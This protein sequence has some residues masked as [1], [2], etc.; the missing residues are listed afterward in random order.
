[1]N[2]PLVAEMIA[3]E[4]LCDGQL[5]YLRHSSYQAR[6]PLEL[7]IYHPPTVSNRPLVFSNPDPSVYEL[8]S[9]FNVPLYSNDYHPFISLL[10]PL[11]PTSSHSSLFTLYSSFPTMPSVS[12]PT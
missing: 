4:T 10:N 11:V 7:P 5:H 8:T 12:L 9:G 1:M 3:S 6:Y 2:P